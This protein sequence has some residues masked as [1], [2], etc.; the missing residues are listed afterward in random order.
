MLNAN[1]AFLAIQSVDVNANANT[2]Q[3]RSYAQISSYLSV[4][5]NIGSI[6]LGL[7]LMRQNRTKS[8]ETADE[9]VSHSPL[10]L[11]FY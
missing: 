2:S 8:R 5:A 7:L 4:V 11:F 6:I 10:T 1:V 3:Y 9:A